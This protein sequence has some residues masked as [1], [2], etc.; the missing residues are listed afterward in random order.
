MKKGTEDEDYRMD[1]FDLQ[2]GEN[3]DKLESI[4]ENGYMSCRSSKVWIIFG[5]WIIYLN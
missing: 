3:F 2:Q 1:N 5:G 4:V